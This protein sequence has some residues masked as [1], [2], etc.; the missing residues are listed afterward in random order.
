MWPN[1]GFGNN[2]HFPPNYNQEDFTQPPF[3]GDQG[4][5]FFTPQPNMMQFDEMNG[6]SY[7]ANGNFQPEVGLF[8]DGA[9]IPNQ[10]VNQVSFYGHSGSRPLVVTPFQPPKQAIDCC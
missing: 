6:D 3:G 8:N 5:R 4:Q 9:F 7:M 10:F 1:N 2:G